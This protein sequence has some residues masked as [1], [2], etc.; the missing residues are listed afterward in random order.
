[1]LAGKERLPER[2]RHSG[3]AEIL[4]SGPP[5]A[6]AE[7]GKRTGPAET[8]VPDQGYPNPWSHGLAMA[9]AWTA[10]F[11]FLAGRLSHDRRRGAFVSLLVF[12]HWLVDLVAKPMSAVFPHDTGLPLLFAGSPTVGLGLYRSRRLANLIEYGSLAV[13]L[14]LYLQT[15]LGKRRQLRS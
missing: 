4:D 7:S 11:G 9:I 12:S 2:G 10:L 14:T 3:T 6:T 5:E 1:M 13:G 15:L 8:G